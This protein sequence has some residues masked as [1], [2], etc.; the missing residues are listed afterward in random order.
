MGQES[1]Y[2]SL[3]TLREGWAWVFLRNG[4][5]VG[6]ESG[7]RCHGFGR[8]DRPLRGLDVDPVD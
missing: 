2:R 4:R 8:L 1:E 6:K 7:V 3:E 5:L